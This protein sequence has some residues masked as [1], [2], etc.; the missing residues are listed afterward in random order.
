MLTE[1]SLGRGGEAMVSQGEDIQAILKLSPQQ[2]FLSGEIFD[3]IRVRI[4][5]KK[6]FY[7]QQ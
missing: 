4:E 7:Y 1:K 2:S 3:K 6:D 5:F